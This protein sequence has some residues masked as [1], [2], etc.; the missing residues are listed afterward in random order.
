MDEFVFRKGL[1]QDAA[2]IAGL[3]QQNYNV[4]TE[5][6]ALAFFQRDLLGGMKY[7]VAESNG[8]IAGFASWKEHDRTYHEL[9]ELHAIAVSDEFKGRGLSKSLFDALLDDAKQH[10]A[11]NGHSLRKLYVLTHE[12]NERAIAYYTKVGF[13]KEATIPN[14]YYS[15]LN[16]IVMAIYFRQV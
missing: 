2:H 16:E 9:A 13:K 11:G 4:K 6:E 3:I 10:Y 1:G 7:V 12:N 14:H 15:D 8:Q 5:Q